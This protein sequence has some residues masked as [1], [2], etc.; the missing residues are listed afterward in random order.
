MGQSAP[1]RRGAKTCLVA[2]MVCRKIAKGEEE[3]K[4]FKESRKEKRNRRTERRD[5]MEQYRKLRLVL[6][7]I[8]SRG[9]ISKRCVVE[10]AIL[11][12]EE[13]QR[14]L[15]SR[16]EESELEQRREAGHGM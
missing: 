6:P 2:S 3:I 15:R 9:K 8:S 13:L 10:E 14:Q 4:R 7:N 1:S 12:I 11:Y 16:L 5:I